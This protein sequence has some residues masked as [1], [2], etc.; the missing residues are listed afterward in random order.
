MKRNPPQSDRVLNA[1]LDEVAERFPSVPGFETHSGHGRRVA[2]NIGPVSVTLLRDSVEGGVIL[3]LI[4]SRARGVGHGSAALEA[5]RAIA[6]K[7]HVRIR[8]VPYPFGPRFDAGGRRRLSIAALRK[9][10]ERHGFR[11]HRGEMVQENPKRIRTNS[12][13]YQQSASARPWGHT[14]PG[15]YTS[16]IKEI[17][18]AYG[19]NALEAAKG[20]NG[21][22]DQANY[23]VVFELDTAGLPRLLDDDGAFWIEREWPHIRKEA[24]R[25]MKNRD[26]LSLLVGDAEPEGDVTNDDPV[27]LILGRRGGYRRDPIG[28]LLDLYGPTG[29]AKIVRASG[30]PPIE[31]ANEVYAQ[32]RYDAKFGEDRVVAIHAVKPWWRELLDYDADQER[33]EELEALGWHVV[34][35]E[36]FFSENIGFGETKVLYEGKRHDGQRI[37]YH[38]TWSG[39]AKRAFPHTSR[40]PKKTPFP[41]TYPEDADE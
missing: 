14:S 3:S 26:D 31:V 39:A 36:E 8:L 34:T 23:V 29:A 17:S 28:I 12:L 35:T 1:F 9:W 33:I 38:G 41:V 4:E 27:Y 10:Y 19:F 15:V 18:T 30:P 25:Y 16:S 32:Y 11:A 20:P 40:W 7:Y 37:E 24:L 13:E 5:I 2:V 6:R 22:I 21:D